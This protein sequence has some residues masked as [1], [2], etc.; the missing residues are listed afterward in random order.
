M[1]STYLLLSSMLRLLVSGVR[2]LLVFPKRLGQYGGV[3]LKCFECGYLCVTNYWI[4]PE[5][6][7]GVTHI[8]KMCK[9]CGWESHKMKVPSKIV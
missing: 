7:K 3:I 4:S 2:K 6:G 1:R 8:N 9:E 5:P